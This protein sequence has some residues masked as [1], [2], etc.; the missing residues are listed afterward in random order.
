VN[1]A[2]ATFDELLDI[3]GLDAVYIVTPEETHAEQALKAIARGIPVFMEK[4]IATSAS[5][6]ARVYEAAR[7]AHVYVQVG[8]VLRF[9]AQHAMI[10]ARLDAG[11]F[12]DIATLRTKR[13]CSKDW[14]PI[15]GDRAHTVYETVIH[16]ID[17]I[18][19]FT[20]SRVKSV[21]AV[22]RFVTGRTYPDSLVATLQLENGAVAMLE[23]NWL[24]PATAPQNVTTPD[25]SGTIDAEWELVG[26]NQA[27]RYRL[28]DSG[29]SIAASSGVIQ[30]EVGL[31]PDVY[32]SIGG[33][34]R[35]EDEH[36]IR[37]V[38]AGVPSPIASL[39]DA[40]HGLQVAEAV[41]QSATSETLVTL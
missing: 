21:F 29:V 9:D 10:R 37:C 25:W 8:F 23:T 24:I 17:L 16:D 4:P 36:F 5:D 28:L 33:A 30:P 2:V 41:I 31:W 38:Q 34:L 20:G 39:E 1:S 19:W 14:F 6:A 22:Q 12:G 35:L 11:E 13:S 15:Y 26:V 32:G 18:L 3:E 40:F 27:A 7:S